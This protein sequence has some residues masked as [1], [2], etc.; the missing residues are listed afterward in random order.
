MPRKG[1][2]FERSIC[3]QLSRWWTNDPDT[4]VIF[5]RTSQS[6][7]RATSRVKRGKPATAAHCGDIYAVDDRGLPFTR[8][9]T[10]ELKTG[11][12]TATIHAL[13]D[14]PT[15]KPPNRKAS[16]QAWV[17]QAITASRNAN[18]PFWA[19]IHHRSARE[20]ILT[21]PA[22][23]WRE[24]HCSY[25]IVDPPILR[26]TAYP[27][28][29]ASTTMQI[30]SPF[31]LVS[32]RLSAFLAGIDPSEIRQL[33]DWLCRTDPQSNVRSVSATG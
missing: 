15:D 32:M 17:V 22:E 25:R 19:I 28:S 4:D 24:L 33:S 16:Y 14:Q 7:G 31:E 27:K 8:L 5:W 11:Y 30:D 3:K 20:T 26:L 1:G 10:P 21:I 29:L 23:L 9:I 18:T 2:E 13:L 12:S 6:G